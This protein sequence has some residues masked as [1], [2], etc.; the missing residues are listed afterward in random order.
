MLIKTLAIFSAAT[1]AVAGPGSCTPDPISTQRYTLNLFTPGSGAS[2]MKPL[3]VR[4][5][6]I[7]YG[8]SQGYSYFKL[9]AVGDN[10][11]DVE[12]PGQPPR[13]LYAADNGRLVIN[14]HPSKVG[15]GY[16][17][18]WEFSGDGSVTSLSYYG[19]REFYSCSSTDDPLHGGQVVYVKK[20]D[21][22]CPKPIKFTVGATKD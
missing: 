3:Q 22:A 21:Y 18:G 16:R 2:G 12:S 5:T 15:N 4:G 13:E 19:A 9:N 1:A 7:V 11:A 8:L 14:A 10:L 17:G 20:G 6:S